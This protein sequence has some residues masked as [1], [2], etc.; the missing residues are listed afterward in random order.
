MNNFKKLF[1]KKDWKA[2]EGLISKRDMH[3]K[4]ILGVI[5]L[6]DNAGET[7]YLRYIAKVMRI[8][9]TDGLLFCFSDIS[10]DKNNESE[11]L[12]LLQKYR[13]M[14]YELDN[15]LNVLPFPVWKRGKDGKI[16]F[17]NQSY[18]DLLS[19]AGY[20]NFT[21]ELHDLDYN[22]YEQ[23]Q[24]DSNIQTMVTKKVFI[25]D[26]QPMIMRINEVRLLGGGSIGYCYFANEIDN[27]ERE[28]TA[29][30]NTLKKLLQTSTSAI[31][32]VD[33]FGYVVLYN[34][35]F[36]N[37]FGL[38]EYTLGNKLSFSSLL[39]KIR[40]KGKLP[41]MKD[42]KEFKTKQ[43]KYIA[44]PSGLEYFHMYLPNGTT[45]RGSVTPVQG[46][47]II[48]RYEDISNQLET[49]RAYNEKANVLTTMV[50]ASVNPIVIFSANGKVK[51]YNSK[52]AEV[53]NIDNSFLSNKPHFEEVLLMQEATLVGQKEPLLHREALIHAFEARN[54]ASLKLRFIKDKYINVS[55]EPLPDH[56][57]MVQYNFT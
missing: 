57:L 38:D 43:M 26:N 28:A 56:S 54:N 3:A 20:T 36:R 7:Q 8:N 52:F 9:E 41:E 19:K 30:N 14:S 25:I 24:A 49:E 53:F 32:I 27:L 12:Q 46:G 44:E 35:L 5:E 10:E 40:E 21:D 45:L 11:L 31:L 37:I 22:N 1:T 42:Y 51:D 47:D 50:K 48:F 18:I 15:L 33:N 13:L 34:D 23:L 16:I 29:L 39:D 6:H 4:D 17:Y 55:I 2:I